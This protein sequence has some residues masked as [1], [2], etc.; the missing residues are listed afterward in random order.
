MVYIE[1]EY[2][3]EY[4]KAGALIKIYGKVVLYTE[5]MNILIESMYIETKDGERYKID[6]EKN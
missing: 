6:P 3:E 2:G 5:A 4:T 1:D